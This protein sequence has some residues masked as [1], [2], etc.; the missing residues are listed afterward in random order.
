M[1]SAA[2]HLRR[3]LRSLEDLGRHEDCALAGGDGRAFLAREERATPL[4]LRLM[5]LVGGAAGRIDDDLRARGRALVESRRERR[6]R[7]MHLLET[8]RDELGQLDQ[9]RARARAIRPAYTP[10][11]T[12]APRPGSGFVAQG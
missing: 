1:R 6:L 12:R 7:L 4:V 11:T 10:A 2:F 5:A 3:L 9:A 8:T